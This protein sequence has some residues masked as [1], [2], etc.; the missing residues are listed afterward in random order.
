MADEYTSGRAQHYSAIIK[1][2][3]NQIHKKWDKLNRLMSDLGKN[4]EGLTTVE[5]F[6]NTCDETAEW[7]LEK[8][9]KID[10]GGDF[11]KDLKTVQALH[12]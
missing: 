1:Q 5:I 2:R 10:H 11:G 4:V 3:Q 7:M 8:L 6:N 9:E 12:R